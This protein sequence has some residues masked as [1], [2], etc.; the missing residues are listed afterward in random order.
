MLSSVTA[1]GAEFL[2]ITAFYARVQRLSA[3]SCAYLHLVRRT[4]YY[5]CT[6]VDSSTTLFCGWKDFRNDTNYNHG[7]EVTII[8]HVGEPDCRQAMSHCIGLKGAG[9]PWPSHNNVKKLDKCV[10]F[11]LI[12]SGLF[13]RISTFTLLLAFSLSSC[14]AF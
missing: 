13:I 14:S 9:E 12:R 8:T 3:P 11:K 2:Y 10:L 5:L 1:A 7:D 4:R 6:T